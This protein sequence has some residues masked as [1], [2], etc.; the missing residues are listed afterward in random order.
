MCESENI[1]TYKINMRMMHRIWVM[2]YH[3]CVT[4]TLYNFEIWLFIKN[5]MQEKGGVDKTATEQCK[6]A[7]PPKGEYHNAFY[8]I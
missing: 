6:C 5:I 3:T 2:S 4:P 1:Q 8:P 7:P